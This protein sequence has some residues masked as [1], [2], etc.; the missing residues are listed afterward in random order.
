M[1]RLTARQVARYAEALGA[2]V[3]EAIATPSA[4]GPLGMI[5]LAEEVRRRLVSRGGR[6]TMPEW[7]MKRPIP[8]C[9]RNW[10]RLTAIGRELGLSPA[11][12]AALLI[13]RALAI[14]DAGNRGSTIRYSSKRSR[15]RAA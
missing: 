11:Q 12:F 13:E 2:D 3:V 4:Q 1:S 6:P 5:Q 7:D 8:L 14:V 15:A 9:R 10:L